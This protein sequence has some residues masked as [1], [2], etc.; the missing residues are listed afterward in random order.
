M[1][2]I[3]R[4][5]HL[6]YKHRLGQLWWFSLVK[7]RLKGDLTERSFQN[8]KGAYKEKQSNFYTGRE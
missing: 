8:L 2:M 4:L 3:T 1:K 6:S 5:E 7:R